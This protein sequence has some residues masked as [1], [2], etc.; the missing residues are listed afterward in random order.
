MVFS[1]HSL[2]TFKSHELLAFVLIILL[3]VQALWRLAS[4]GKIPRKY[5][6]LYFIITLASLV[7]VIVTS[8]YGGKLVFEHGIGVKSLKVT[9]E[10]F[11]IPENSKPAFQFVKPDT[12]HN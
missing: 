6:H 3:Q 12:T 5:S 8:Y 9:N 10:R 11:N 1:E 7:F 2:S 4:G